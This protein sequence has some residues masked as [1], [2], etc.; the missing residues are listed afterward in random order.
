[1]NSALKKK[2]TNLDKAVRFLERS[3][4]RADV[5][6]F[7]E[8]FTT[9]YALDLIGG[10]FDE[11]AEPIPGPTTE[12]LGRQAREHGLGILGTIVE[13]DETEG[14]ALYDTTFLLDAQGQLLGKYRKSHLYPPERRYFRAGDR[15]PVFN[16][17]GLAVG[18]AICFEHAFPHI[19]TTLAL[20]GA[21]VVFIP[22]VVPVGYEYLLDLRTRARAQDNQIFTVAVNRVGREGNIT[23]C[24]LSQ[25]AS[26]RGEVVARAS[27]AEEELLIAELDLGLI[28][29]EREQEPVLR[30]LRPGL[31]Q[32]L[33]GLEEE[34]DVERACC[35]REERGTAPPIHH[36]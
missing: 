6:C 2:G 32:P 31:Y 14:G 25:V 7:P 19:F 29:K 8:L 15:L 33:P 34:E 27:A 13:R 10:D 23:Y 4:G 20:H 28:S 17:D 5:V 24:G 1:M 22:S 18:V 9:G 30:N 35:A 3:S 16:L 12:L 26:P 11:L 36:Q 21:Q